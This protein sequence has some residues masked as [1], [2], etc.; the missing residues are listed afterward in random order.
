MG[1]KL[2]YLEKQKKERDTLRYQ[3]M[4]KSSRK[5]L[6]ELKRPSFDLLDDNNWEYS[7]Q[8]FDLESTGFVI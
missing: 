5:K 8:I 7:E 2:T 1:I 4:K 3:N 6:T